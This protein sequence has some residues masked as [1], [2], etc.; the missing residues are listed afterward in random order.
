VIALSAFWTLLLTTVLATPEWVWY[1]FWIAVGAV[2][3]VDRV[4]S[5]WEGGWRARLLAALLLPELAY[6]LFLN[7]VYV[8]GVV[9]ITFARRA[10]WG[11]VPHAGTAAAGPEATS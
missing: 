8:K 11:H 4:V 6:D 7:V 1:P 5:V 3:V 2:F 9:D 10:Q